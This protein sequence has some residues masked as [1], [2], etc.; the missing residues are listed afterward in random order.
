[1]AASSLLPTR[2]HSAASWARSRS[3]AV[4][5][6]WRR[7]SEARQAAVLSLARRK[8]RER[9][10]TIVRKCWCQRSRVTCPVHALGAWF[11]S[12]PVGDAPWAGW[13]ATSVRSALRSALRH[14]GVGNAD[15]YGTH[16]FRRGHAQDIV[17]FGG[18]V[19]DILKAGD[20]QMPA[21]M[22]Y[23][24]VEKLER[25]AVA[26][27]HIGASS[28]DDE[29]G[30]AVPPASS[31]AITR[32]VDANAVAPGPF[33]RSLTLVRPVGRSLAGYASAAVSLPGSGCQRAC[34]C[35]RLAGGGSARPQPL[36]PWQWV[37]YP[38]ASACA[39]A[40]QPPVSF[41]AAGWRIGWRRTA[42]ASPN[43]DWV[44]YSPLWVA[45]RSNVAAKETYGAVI[46]CY[47]K[48]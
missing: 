42:A 46:T 39:L 12:H 48:S 44:P 30:E 28:S 38:C 26:E 22:R 9:R 45:S 14:A 10:T 33:A 5:Q 4:G 1:M 24:D 3:P 17:E 36:G 23:L 25:Q 40:R 6:K 41:D 37:W 11:N 15:A 21:W 19:T 47:C 18:R 35:R 20:W 31:D 7:R 13:C 29:G 27:A 34:G 16:A 32:A 2:R 43:V 8:N